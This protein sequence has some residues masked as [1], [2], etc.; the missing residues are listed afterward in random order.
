MLKGSNTRKRPRI[1]PMAHVADSG[2]LNAADSLRLHR[3][4]YLMEAGESGLYLFSACAVATLVMAPRF[5]HPAIPA[6]ATPFAG[7]GWA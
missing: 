6:E 3:P 5:A 7:Y 2:T 4:E 1:E